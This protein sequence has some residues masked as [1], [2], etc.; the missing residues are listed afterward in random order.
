MP[1]V[2]V[3]YN[4]NSEEC[5]AFGQTV[6]ELLQRRGVSICVSE[7]VGPF[8]CCHPFSENHA[9]DFVIIIGGDGTILSALSREHLYDIPLCCIDKGTL[10]FLSETVASDLPCLIDNLLAGRYTVE[11]RKMIGVRYLSEQTTKQYDESEWLAFALNEVSVT[12]RSLGGVMRCKVYIGEQFV[13]QYAADGV[14]V[15]TPTG[16][17]AYS[18]SAGGPIVSPDVSC[19]LVTPVCAHSL[20][21]RPLVIS[22]D[23]MVTLVPQQ[24][25]GLM[26]F[27][28]QRAIQLK[29]GERI[30]VA[31]APVTAKFI[32]FDPPNF[33][34]LL[35]KK[36]GEWTSP[37]WKVGRTDEE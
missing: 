22:E 30:Q 10:G 9:L 1:E 11:S 8:K 15:S 14:L 23:Q 18:L 37:T 24:E 7:S 31:K 32:R 20:Y 28:G 35:R 2:G 26:V 6:I 21:S 5:T 36:M 17:T 25:D 16:S 34:E 13:S 19:F 33:Y 4:Q 27:D 29:R 3:Y 12:R